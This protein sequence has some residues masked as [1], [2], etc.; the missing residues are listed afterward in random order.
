MET[1]SGDVRQEVQNDEGEWAGWILRGEDVC[2]KG[3]GNGKEE[4]KEWKGV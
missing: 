4:M 1:L 2:V 3:K